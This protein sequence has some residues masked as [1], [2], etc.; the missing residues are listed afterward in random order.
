MSCGAGV[1]VMLEGGPGTGSR[2]TLEA[3]LVTDGQSEL[4]DVR[5]V[6]MMIAGIIDAARNA[7]V[8]VGI[9]G[10]APSDYP[11]FT[12]F[13]VERGIGSISLNPD[14]VAKGIEAVADAERRLQQ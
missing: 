5:G 13:L 11:E 3:G 1:R 8:K 2:T 4:R 12:R 6:L 7:A 9:C 10:Q 14:A